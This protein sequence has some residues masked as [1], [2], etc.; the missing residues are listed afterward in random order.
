MR[1]KAEDELWAWYTEWSTIARN[2]IHNGTLLR[3]LGYLSGGKPSDEAPVPTTGP[4]RNRTPRPRDTSVRPREV[5]IRTPGPVWL[6]GW[7]TFVLG[8]TSCVRPREGD[9]RTPGPVA[10]RGGVEFADR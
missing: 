2:A 7:T 1:Q 6:E 3:M 4:A 8:G 9:S 10:P 5:Y